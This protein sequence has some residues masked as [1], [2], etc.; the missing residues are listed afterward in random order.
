M[1]NRK[2]ATASNHARSPKIAAR[3]Q[4]TKQAIVRSP[5]SSTLRSVAEGST[6]SPP[7]P[8]ND[9]PQEAFLVQNPATVAQDDFKQTA[10][11][12]D[13]K[14]GFDLSFA[15]ANVRA[16]Q[17]KLLEIAQANMQFAFEFA[18]RFA[19]IRSPVEFLKVIEEFS[20]RRIAMFR[21]YSK[22]MAELSVHR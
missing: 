9:S 19:T 2:P 5:K 1:R 22:E 16:Y 11:D 15:T 14:T 13:S 8:D 20:S 18:Q 4:R 3:A 21:K 10:G 6:Q 17:A 12:N 7:E